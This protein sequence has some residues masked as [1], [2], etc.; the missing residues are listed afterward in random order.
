MEWQAW[1]TIA[2]IVLVFYGLARSLGPP[3]VL[4]VGSIVA[5]GV[6]GVITLEEMFAGF[7]N[8]GMLTVA[9]LFIV[10]AALR[11]TGALDIIGNQLLGKTKKEKT[12]LLRLALP[13]IGM[14]AF[15]NNT[16][17]VAMLVPII[18]DW[19]RK[20][21]ISP[22]RLLLPVSYL[23]ILGGT[24]TLIGTSTNLVV[25][26]M[27]RER[28]VA[29]D[30]QI[31]S[32]SDPQTSQKLEQTKEALHPISLFEMA[33]VGIPFAIAGAIY[34][35]FVGRRL[36]PDR[37]DLLEQMGESA[38]EYLVDMVIQ[39]GGRLINQSITEA[40]LRHL[41]G[42]FLIEITR[43][44]QI[45]SPVSPDV[46]L[47]QGDRLTF[48]GV[49][50]TIVDLERIP[51][52]IPA[53]DESYETRAV[54]RRYQRLCEAVISATSPLI[55]KNIRDA[56][57][58]ALYNAAVV[59]VHRGGERLKGR[60]GDI[61]LRAG[62]T[63]LLQAT[64]HFASAHRNNPD[65]F[66]VSSIDEA[67]PVRHDR[68]LMSLGFL[69]LLIVLM[70]TGIVPTVL[71]AFLIAGLM[72]GTRCISATDARQSVD[73]QTL[74]TIAA[75]FGLG[76]A[77]D[78]SGAARTI[79]NL[80]FDATQNLGPIAAIAAVYLITTIFTE[81]ITNNAA[82]AL[83]FPFAIAV[84][85]AFG[86]NPRPFAMVVAFAASASLCTP[87]G[88]QTNMMVFGPGGYRFNDFV[89]VGLPLNLLL[90]VVATTLIPLVWPLNM[91]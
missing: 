41:P 5:V 53:A 25:Y 43:G 56:N 16:P 30:K 21:R 14:S 80:V 75:A 91:S 12:A 50:S 60:I 70:A 86:V 82:A 24:C 26:G 6:V 46:I 64:T 33:A 36:L 57:F 90:C 35:L 72:V 17:V 84:A 88:Y 89:R 48:T 15:L 44:E 32:E 54:E 10:A 18:T 3:D 1:F 71:A 55:G 63:L 69:G 38:R 85:D 8:P 34:L 29:L 77:L 20:H 81:L 22:S 67:R 58:R 9:A 52:L 78:N 28:V 7:S 74:L 42:L 61:V 66:L 45:I 51:G 79:A 68:L 40:G 27:M 62:D 2:I 76:K 83:I 73:W 65:F 19:C 87:I 37:K 23:A 39:P 31:A 49:V 4:L 13:T 11:E 47:Q 59:A